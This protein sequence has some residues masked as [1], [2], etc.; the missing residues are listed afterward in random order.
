MSE[1]TFLVSAPVR[2]GGGYGYGN[3]IDAPPEAVVAQ[4]DTVAAAVSDALALGYTEGRIWNQYNGASADLA[5]WVRDNQ[6]ALGAH[7]LALAELE[8]TDPIALEIDYSA[9]WS[10]YGGEWSDE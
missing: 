3:H 5:E 2:T 10:A 6:G 1:P 9:P 8:D 7:R 4:G